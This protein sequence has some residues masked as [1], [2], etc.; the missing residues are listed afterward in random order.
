MASCE[1]VLRGWMSR[2][3]PPSSRRNEKQNRCLA[4]IANG[5]VLAAAFAGSRGLVAGAAD[6]LDGCVAAA[7]S[8]FEVVRTGEEQVE[9]VRFALGAQVDGARCGIW[10]RPRRCRRLCSLD[11]RRYRARWGGRRC[12][13]GR[14]GRWMGRWGRL[15]GGL[16]VF[17]EELDGTGD[18]IR[19]EAPFAPAFVRGSA[20]GG[21]EDRFEQ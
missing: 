12:L 18:F 10:C 2:R 21:I 3:L 9:V 1:C 8:A 4:R 7:V 19:A 13:P 11:R 6:V 5:E 14:C 16:V 17:K 20:A 15:R